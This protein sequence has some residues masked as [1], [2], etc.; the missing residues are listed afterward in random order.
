MGRRDAASPRDSA[1]RP[2]ARLLVGL[3]PLFLALVLLA[4]LLVHR[5]YPLARDLVF[6]ARQPFTDASVGLGGTAPR[7]VPLDAVVSVATALLDGAVLARIALLLAL[8]LAGWG[9][10]RLTAPLGTWARLA[11]SGFAVWNP[12]VVERMALG[13]WA[14]VTAYAALPWI[15]LAAARYRRTGERGALASVVLWSAL[16]SLTPTGGLLA[17]ATSL[18]AGAARTRRTWWLVATGVLLQLPWVVPSFVG[19][20]SRTADPAGV[21]VFAPGSDA[22]GSPALALAGLGGIWDGLSV[23]ATRH[24]PFALVTAALVVL[25]LVLGLRRWWRVAGDLAP[26]VAGLGFG[27]LLLALLLTTPPGQSVLR[28]AID[29]VPGFGLLRDGQKFLAPFVV[30]VGWVLAAGVDGLLS[31][32]APH[33]IE[34]VGS[35]GI[36][37][38]LLPV[39]LI[40]DGAGKVWSTVRP[41]TYPPGLAHV[42]ATI[43]SSSSDTGV[44]TLPWRSYRNFSWGS[45][46]TSSDP[47]VRMLDR[48]VFTSE[49]LTVGD[50]TVHGESGVVTRLGSALAR[51]TPAQVLPAFGIGWVVVYPDDPA[52]RDLDLT[53]LHLVY[54]TPE[55]RLYAVP[56][57][58]GVPEPE[59]WRRVAV[60]AADLLALLTV[61]AAAV[62][63][64]SAWRSRRRRR[65]WRD[66]VLESRH[67]PQEESC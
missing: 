8:V 55:V 27:G 26:R 51:G 39:L 10:L 23:P 2:A 4:P 25:V 44:V 31:R 30:L 64:L 13:Q 36:L 42:V 58:A 11:A 12:F 21:A 63:R 15:L 52:A 7:A 6:V 19:G 41:V 66:A 20:A 14:L 37:F 59:A 67:P 32:L 62:V 18:T 43:D 65:P 28:W 35:L 47:L 33:G 50:T 57:A 17:L 3:W 9:M 40:P 24:S 34:V 56:G 29:T 54:A 22:A 49:D 60:A 16:A 5:G 61:L 1:P 53:G 38:V 46:T 48:P 45:G